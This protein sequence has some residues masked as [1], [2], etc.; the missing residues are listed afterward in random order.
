MAQSQMTT[1]C[2]NQTFWDKNEDFC[3]KMLFVFYYNGKPNLILKNFEDLIL[4]ITTILLCMQYENCCIDVVSI[5][6]QVQ[7]TSKWESKINI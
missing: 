2:D 7:G 4:R 5:N 1:I 6:G 3:G